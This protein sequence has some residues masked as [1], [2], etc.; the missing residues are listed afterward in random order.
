[1]IFDKQYAG[2]RR[3][4]PPNSAVLGRHIHF[5]FHVRG[6]QYIINSRGTIDRQR[7]QTEEA[8]RRSFHLLEGSSSATR[9]D[10]ASR[11]ISQPVQRRELWCMSEQ[12]PA[13]H[14]LCLCRVDEN[15]VQLM[16]RT[17]ERWRRAVVQWTNLT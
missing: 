7:E 6:H 15:P 17:V 16:Q 12:Q 3:A 8:N 1:M 10:T 5:H 11:R 13:M 4:S 14:L 9:D 2:T